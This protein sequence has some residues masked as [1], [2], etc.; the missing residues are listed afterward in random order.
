MGP[1]ADT[2]R[3]AE[4]RALRERLRD[5]SKKSEI[6][7][8]LEELD[9]HPNEGVEPRWTRAV[10]Q[11]IIPAQTPITTVQP[12]SIRREALHGATPYSF[13]FPDRGIGLDPLIVI[14]LA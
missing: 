3:H 1:K 10:T 12:P 9:I 8:F 14:V 5:E 11:Q 7:G 2:T 13:L 6:S 4:T